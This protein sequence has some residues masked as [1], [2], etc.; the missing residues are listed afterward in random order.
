MGIHRM[1][2]PEYTAEDLALDVQFQQSVRPR[3]RMQAHGAHR[4]TIDRASMLIRQAGLTHDIEANAAFLQ[5]W[6]NI[7][8]QI[9]DTSQRSS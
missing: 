5:V 8:M 7:R 1:D 9:D 3:A 4:E 2:S 6:S